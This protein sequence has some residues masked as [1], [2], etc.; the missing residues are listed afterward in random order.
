MSFFCSDTCRRE[1]YQGFCGGCSD[2]FGDPNICCPYVCQPTSLTSQILRIHQPYVIP[3][4]PL[5]P[6]QPI[7]ENEVNVAH[8]YSTEALTVNDNATM[9]F[10]SPS[11][12]G[13][14]EFTSGGNQIFLNSKG[15]YIIN[16]MASNSNDAAGIWGIVEDGQGMTVPLTFGSTANQGSVVGFAKLAVENPPKAISFMN[17]SGSSLTMNN[18]GGIGSSFAVTISKDKAFTEN[19]GWQ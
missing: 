5:I 13:V 11:T 2:P 9:T 19:E 10:N 17:G 8:I 6:S 3:Y 14:I 7:G 12:S 4:T 16:F 15:N 18:Q 1:R